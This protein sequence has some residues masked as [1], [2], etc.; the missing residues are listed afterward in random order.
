MA[1]GYLDGFFI[2]LIV[3]CL[4][5][6]LGKGSEEIRDIKEV[7]VA[8]IVEISSRFHRSKRTQERAHIEEVEVA[9]AVDVCWAIT[10]RL[11]L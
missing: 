6:A 2:G 7:V 11:R 10:W 9:I 4:W 3:S 8:I 1:T 5:T